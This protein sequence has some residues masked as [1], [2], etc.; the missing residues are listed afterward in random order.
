MPERLT[1]N[2]GMVYVF[3]IVTVAEG[4]VEICFR[5]EEGMESVSKGV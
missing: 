1:P 3:G 2:G 4:V 5:S